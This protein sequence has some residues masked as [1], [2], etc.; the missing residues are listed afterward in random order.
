M[1]KNEEIRISTPKKIL[2]QYNENG[3]LIAE[4]ENFY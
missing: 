3:M 1:R 4:W 2:I